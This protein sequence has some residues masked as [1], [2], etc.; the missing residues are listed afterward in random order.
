MS[1]NDESKHQPWKK[2]KRDVL[3]RDCVQSHVLE[4]EATLI[5][6]YQHA[7]PFS[8][9]VLQHVLH[10]DFAAQVL[11]EVKQ[12]SKVNFKESDL[13]RVYQS[14]DMA[15]LTHEQHAET[16][17][18]VLQLRHVLYSTEWRQRMERLCGLAPG[19]LTEQV[20][21]AFN[22]HTSGC[23]L[24]CH[25]DV[26]G[27]R[28]ISYILYLTEPDWTASEGGALE[29]YD[30]EPATANPDKDTHASKTAV[31]KSIPSCTILPTF[32]HLAFFMVEPGVSFHAVQEVFGDRPRLSLQGWYHTTHEPDG[33]E[34][35]TLQ[36]LKT[37]GSTAT[38]NM[39]DDAVPFQPISYPPSID[40]ATTGAQNEQWTAKDRDYLSKYLH[41]T[42]LTDQALQNIGTQFEEDSSVQLQRFLK[43]EWMEK[44]N[45]L[46]NQEE[47]STR[48]T[49][50]DKG[51][52]EQ[53]VT[54]EWK[55]VGPA[56]K[57][58]FLGYQTSAA[59]TED[60]V[61]GVLYHLQQHL[62]C[63]TP[64][65]KFLAQVTSLGL[66]L[67]QRG[68]IRQFRKG[69]DYT[70]AHYGILTRKSVLDATLC[71]VAGD[72]GGNTPQ[73]QEQQDEENEHEATSTDDLIW[74][75]GDSGGFECYIA[76]DENNSDTAAAQEAADEYNQEDDTEL[77]S[78]SPSNNT[79]S[80]VYRDPGTMRF[81]KYVGAS[82]PSSRWDIAMEY[83]VEDTQDEDEEEQEANDSDA[84]SQNQSS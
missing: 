83:D 69:L 44:L 58:R 32:N 28:K 46:R 22:C 39:K 7:K 61:G 2:L 68:R 80:L 5:Q 73:Q 1:D 34:G 29:L 3:I 15:N 18:T 42:Y 81:I 4:N 21:C 70:V 11:S 54:S 20:D 36:Q 79:L 19:T 25:D 27:T 53:G 31:P 40:N 30:R 38:D 37:M 62:L 12:N 10:E 66:P 17:P 55:L 47:A 13:F 84:G 52:Y 74:Q 9:G 76:A 43:S 72:G 63:S 71:F 77:L 75:S 41:E 26:I 49:I 14:I 57:Q 23:H 56:H 59:P 51:Y 6:T 78:V 64:F 48:K 60:T 82:A 45:R 67:G 65:Q 35:A 50:L 24:L 8:H 16:H 33:M